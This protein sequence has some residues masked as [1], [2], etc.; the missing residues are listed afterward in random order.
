MRHRFAFPPALFLTLALSFTAASSWADAF[1]PI[2]EFSDAA[3][4][5]APSN[6]VLA[7]CSVGETRPPAISSGG[8]FVVPGLTF[9]T[10]LNPADCPACNTGLLVLRTANFRAR[11]LSGVC[12][13]TV[14]VT[15]LGSQA[16][17][18]CIVPDPSH[19]ICG[20]VNLDITSPGTAAFTASVPLPAN[21][22]I[23]TTAFLRVRLLTTG[24][25]A[26]GQPSWGTASGG[27]ISCRSF[28]EGPG[29][30]FT[31]ACGFLNANP[32]QW[33]D[34]DCCDPTPNLRGTWGRVKML[35]R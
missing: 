23:S 34:A 3:Q 4:V 17:P 14:E 2:Q 1:P 13:F 15:I 35:Y 33:V 9:Y 31:D 30:P 8:G 28:M 32:V 19:V 16:G 26:A 29:L 18:A 25:C 11:T 27:C 24:G 5:I 21:C 10:L 7:T 6:A 20:P 12:T 22:C